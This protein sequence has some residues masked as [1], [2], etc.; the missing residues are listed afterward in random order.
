M[1][2]ISR[3]VVAVLALLLIAGAV[4][5]LTGGTS[6]PRKIVRIGDTELT[7]PADTPKNVWAVTRAAM[8]QLAYRPWYR[9]CIIEQAKRF[10]TPAQARQFVQ[11]PGSGAERSALTLILKAEP[12]CERPGRE[13]VDPSATSAQLSAIRDQIAEAL[14][15]FLE[16]EGSARRLTTCAVERMKHAT[17]GQTLE[18]VNGTTAAREAVSAVLLNACA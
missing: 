5:A 8:N 11:E 10:V 15:L 6:A 12:R 14:R 9:D 17:D 1:R 4:R 18:M 7:L 16:K 13:A 2:L 3:T